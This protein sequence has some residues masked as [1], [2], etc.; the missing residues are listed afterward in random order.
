MK[1]TTSSV[2]TTM[3]NAAFLQEVK[4]SNIQFWQNVHDFKRL[5]HQ[6]A[7]LSELSAKLVRLLSEL[8]DSMALEFSLE[9]TY[10]YIEGN[11]A[12]SSVSA[13]KAGQAKQQHRELYLQLH[14][15]SES[16][17]E[18]QYRGT[19]V[20]DFAAIVMVCKEFLTALEAH[21][22]H[23]SELIRYELGIGR[24]GS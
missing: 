2:T 22:Q 20:E 13:H 23:E 17:E 9:E 7:E 19:I 10:G 24:F 3:V 16:A 14:E 4:D 21:E 8:R 15:I 1:I 5:L 11:Y 12:A 6:S 18:A